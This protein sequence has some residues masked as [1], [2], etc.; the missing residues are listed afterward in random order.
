[1]EQFWQFVG[2]YWWLVFPL[3]G[4]LGVLGS[5][6]AV[7]VGAVRA[8]RSCALADMTSRRRL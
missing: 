7:T 5:V 1:V 8:A 4:V 6:A 3:A 2:G